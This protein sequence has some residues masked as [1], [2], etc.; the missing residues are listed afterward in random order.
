M[1]YN[2]ILKKLAYLEKG[3]NYNE[4][5]INKELLALVITK[6]DKVIFSYYAS[7]DYH[8]LR[9]DSIDKIREELSMHMVL[10]ILKLGIHSRSTLD[11]NKPFEEFKQDMNKLAAQKYIG[12]EQEE[13]K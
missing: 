13:I 10:L 5:N 7:L 8:S 1:T 12:N 2:E 4:I 6:N 9:F 3:I 11:T